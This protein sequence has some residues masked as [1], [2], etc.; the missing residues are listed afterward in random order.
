MNMG[1]GCPIGG[2]GDESCTC[3]YNNAREGTAVDPAVSADM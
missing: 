2:G 1:G 3:T